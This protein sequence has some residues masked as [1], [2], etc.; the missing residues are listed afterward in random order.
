[1][2]NVVSK[3]L[4][5]WNLLAFSLWHDAYSIS[6]NVLCDLKN[7]IY[8]ISISISI[9]LL[10]LDDLL[11]KWIFQILYLIAFPFLLSLPCSSEPVI[12]HPW[13]AG[14]STCG[15]LNWLSGEKTKK[16]LMRS[17][18]G[19]CSINAST[20]VSVKLPMVNSCLSKFLNVLQ[21]ALVRLFKTAPAHHFSFL[22]RDI[23]VVYCFYLLASFIS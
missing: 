9:L 14:W 19:F 6:V 1:M 5:L 7:Y 8:I 16:V 12:F 23:H 18:A 15:M 13:I 11:F 2:L 3:I 10:F 22:K 21:S 20:M 4:I 17:I